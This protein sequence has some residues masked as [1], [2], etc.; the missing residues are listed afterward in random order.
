MAKSPARVT[1][2]RADAHATRL[3]LIQL[4]RILR[5]TTPGLLFGLRDG[6]RLTD[7]SAA[8][9]ALGEAVERILNEAQR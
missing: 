7:I 5:D 8:D 1:T 3:V 4:L 2:D 9:A 6:L